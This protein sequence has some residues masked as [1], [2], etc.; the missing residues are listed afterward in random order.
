MTFDH[1]DHLSS[2]ELIAIALFRFGDQ[3]FTK[4]QLTSQLSS[5]MQWTFSNR[6]IRGV[7]EKLLL[8]FA[9]GYVVNVPGPRGGDGW[10]I[11]EEGVAGVDSIELPRDQIQ[12]KEA[13]DMSQEIQARENPGPLLV[14]LVQDLQPNFRAQRFVKNLL[15]YWL[16][17]GC[18]S[19]NQVLKLSE[20]AGDYAGTAVSPADYVGRSPL[21]WRSPHLKAREQQKV[22]A[23]AQEKARLK[24]AQRQAAEAQERA[25]EIF[26]FLTQLDESGMLSD[27]D[28][29]M[30]SVFPNVKVNAK[31][32]RAAFT[33]DGPVRLRTCISAIAFGKPPTEIWGVSQLDGW[34]NTPYKA[35]WRQL[36]Q[37]PE[38]QAVAKK[39]GY[40][41]P[42][43]TVGDADADVDGNTPPE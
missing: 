23:L 5:L 6:L 29:I 25:K 10:S 26:E 31:N 42:A 27:V 34:R 13:R 30:K 35:Y 17:K 21:E 4:S 2:D 32:K 9:K 15:D 7:S 37:S 33:G 43:T 3:R 24:E 22:D 11:T 16:K 8:A 18:L 38:Y 40:A 39:M 12:K 28:H 36:T 20:I 14:Q 41:I 1:I 19:E